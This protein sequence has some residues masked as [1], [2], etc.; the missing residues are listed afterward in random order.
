MAP[1]HG[2]VQGELKSAELSELLQTDVQNV[3]TGIKNDQFCVPSL[4]RFV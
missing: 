4:P 1:W 3:Q 2:G